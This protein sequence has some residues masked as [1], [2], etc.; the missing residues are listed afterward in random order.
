MTS[1]RFGRV[2]ILLVALAAVTVGCS[3]GATVVPPGPTV[4]STSSPPLT[5]VTPLPTVAPS[6]SVVVGAGESWLVYQLWD[7]RADIRLVRPDGTGN[8]P[9]LAG[10]GTG[11][12][13]FHPDWA[14]DG[15]RIAY[16]ANNAIWIANA[17]GSG[18]RQV[19]S[20]CIDPCS[21]DYP[22][23]SPDGASIAYAR[24]QADGDIVAHGTIEVV[25]VASGIELT[26][27]TT[28]GPE[29]PAYPRWSP[30]GESLVVELD[31]FNDASV[32]AGII[33]ASVIATFGVET[34]ATSLKR[35]TDGEMFAAYPDWSPDGSRIAFSTY[36]LGYRDGDAYADPMPP[37][38]LYTIS[39]DATGLAQLTHNAMG[40][41]LIRR[42]TAS[43]SLSGQPTWSP[44]GRSLIFVQ[45]DGTIWPGWQVASLRADIT[46]LASAAVPQ[47]LRAT[48]PRLR[49]IP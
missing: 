9:L 20:P 6:A 25:D 29:Y 21:E 5:T 48:H 18:S 3:Q 27:L 7:G 13:T 35:L 32:D 1:I 38:D 19:S 42:G 31:R 47:F 37:S 4:G 36:D 28:D 2:R 40:S 12:E 30:D 8:H 17:D 41:E 16:V 11:T 34:G 45:V 46:G 26:V 44:D 39:P 15:M 14:P 22:A 23:W 24:S 49:P 43:G 10:A 33:V